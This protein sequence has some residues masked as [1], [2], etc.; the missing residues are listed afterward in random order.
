MKPRIKIADK[1]PVIKEIAK[2]NFEKFVLLNW[3]YEKIRKFNTVNPKKKIA[4]I[5]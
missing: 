3:I 2:S 5:L 4:A 1:A